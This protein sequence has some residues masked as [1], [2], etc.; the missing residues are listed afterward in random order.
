[1][2]IRKRVLAVGLTLGSIAGLAQ[3]ASGKYQVILSGP[4]ESVNRSANSIVVLGHQLTVRNAAGFQPGHV[5]NVFGAVLS[6]G[7]TK[8]AIVQNTLRYAAGGDQVA[9]T[10]V[11]RGVDG[12]SGRI[13][14]DG[15]KVDY[16][17]LLGNGRFSPPAIGELVQVLG[18]QPRAGGIVLAAQLIKQP[19]AGV[20]G[21][22]NVLGVSGGG[23]VLGVSGGGNGLGVSG[24][25]N[26]LGVSGGGNG[27][28]V[29]GGGNGLGVSGGGNGLG[30][31]GGGNG[32]GVSGGGSP[33]R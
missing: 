26:G 20:S 27:L 25:G 24:G 22:G 19:P 12:L 9:V 8:A 18:T 31:S 16:T 28:G 30:V 17:A 2:K 7:S 33:T 6:N 15:A 23:N 11:V 29:S 4:I 1:M 10:G 21:G 3:S 14:V 13:I 32:L 5:V